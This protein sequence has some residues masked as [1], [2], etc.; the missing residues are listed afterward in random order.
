[1]SDS[2]RRPRSAVVRRETPA[3]DGRR[4]GATASS[5]SSS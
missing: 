5:S 4:H 2:N 3:R 1:V